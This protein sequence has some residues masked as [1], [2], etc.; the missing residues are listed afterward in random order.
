MAVELRSNLRTQTS[1]QSKAA[2][3]LQIVDIS[4]PTSPTYFSPSLNLPPQTPSSTPPPTPPTTHTMPLD[5]STYHLSLLRLDGRRWNELRRLH[6]QISTQ[7]SADGSSYLEMGNTKIICT[8]SGPAEIR[9]GGRREGVERDNAVVN[10]EVAVAGFSGTDRKRRRGD[11]YVFLFYSWKGGERR[12][13]G[14]GKGL[15]WTNVC[16]GCIGERRR[17]RIRLRRRLRVRCL[18]IY[19]H[20]LRSA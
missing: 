13:R 2:I 9:G 7:A 5:T 10:V 18:R 20:T 6:A 16:V 3:T 15:D 17:C 11:K 4:G 8:V 14:K 1:K 19:T 12:G